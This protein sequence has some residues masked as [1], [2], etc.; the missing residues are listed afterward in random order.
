MNY[1]LKQL[2]LSACIY[3]LFFNGAVADES[4]TLSELFK[5]L[6]KKAWPQ[7]R[8][9]AN[10]IDAKNQNGDI[11][12][13]FTDSVEAINNGN[14]TTAKELSNLVIDQTPG[15]LP[16][17]D[18]L[19]ECLVKDGKQNQ[20]ALIFQDLANNLREGPEKEIAQRKANALR[21]DLSPRFTLDFSVIPSSNTARRTERA[22][23]GNGGVLSEESRA[24]DGVSINGSIQLIKPTFKSKRLLS[25][26]SIKLGG[27]YDTIR[28]KVSPLVGI[29]ARNTWLLSKTKSVYAAPFYEYTWNSGDRF[30]DEYGLRF[31]S[32]IALDQTKLL[33]TDFII[34]NRDFAEPGRDATFIF[35][36]ISNTFL[37]NENNRVKLTGSAFDINSENQFF[38]VS[39][40]SL[41]V[42]L[43]TA[44]ENGFITSL[45]GQIGTRRYDRT[46]T[47]TT[48]EREDNYYSANIGFSH[49]ALTFGGVRPEIVYTYTNQS[50]NDVL[51]DFAAHDIGLK[52]KANY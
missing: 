35:G 44:H 8:A 14:C 52:F 43:E 40:Y 47:L 34:S 15:F 11:M 6:E 41:N 12:L 13:A 28:K 32:N 49:K 20:A 31:G 17:Y 16:A 42:E 2:C 30:F 10:E 24:Q 27:R 46:A 7:A 33:S 45:G 26:V 3:L 29:E 48:Q 25:Q 37:I 38:N 51:N 18:I 23:I 19:A 50:S 9:I 36:A 1:R 22:T 5:A 4:A 39:D 21:P